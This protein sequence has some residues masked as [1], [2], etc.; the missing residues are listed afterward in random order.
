[1]KC[2]YSQGS[3]KDKR[4]PADWAEGVERE[5]HHKE[6]QLP[7]GHRNN[8]QLT[9]KP[10]T[11]NAMARTKRGK[12]RG[13]TGVQEN[14]TEP[15]M[16]DMTRLREELLTI[17]NQIGTQKLDILVNRIR[18]L[19]ISSPSVSIFV[20]PAQLHECV[21][22][23]FEKALGEADASEVCARVCQVLQ[24]MKPVENSEAEFINFRKLLIIRCQKEFDKNYLESLDSDKYSADMAAAQTVE[25]RSNI[26]AAFELTLTK[27][28]RRSL[29]NIIFIGEL[30]KLQ[31]LTA[32][33]MH[34]VI[35]KLL[36]TRDE[37]SLQ[38][39]CRLLISV[40]QILDQETTQRLSKG[41]QNGLNDLSVYFSKMV[42]I[43]QDTK[44]SSRVRSHL[45]F[46]IQLRLADW[47]KTMETTEEDIGWLEVSKQ[48]SDF[49][50]DEDDG[51]FLLSSG[52]GEVLTADDTEE[53]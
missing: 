14:P 2:V 27:F 52:A 13:R 34:G 50:L 30:Y 23:I 9:P 21:E 38:C 41:P 48:L 26:K 19:T 47:K 37:L 18:R 44:V 49:E 35:N 5:N 45:Q 32:R 28:M 1:M 36:Q 17:L 22:V 4:T 31:M 15:R 29:G 43:T 8:P 25:E 46:V 40:G 24:M 33:I 53:Q 7:P 16:E 39:L 20:N 12:E 42:E 51:D 3:P 10:S 6:H 11:S